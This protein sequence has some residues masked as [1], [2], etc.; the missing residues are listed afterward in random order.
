MGIE[1]DAKL[2][3]RGGKLFRKSHYPSTMSE[4]SSDD[5]FFTP[6][7]SDTDLL[8]SIPI[9]DDLNEP[10]LWDIAEETPSGSSQMV[11]HNHSET[12]HEVMFDVEDGLDSFTVHKF[13]STQ[14]M[15][16][17]AFSHFEE[18]GR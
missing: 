5:G 12:G 2:L 15:S 16:Q 4:S 18:W 6:M 17:S 9:L 7:G 13:Q 14:S 1:C 8:E 11:S 3:V 10:E